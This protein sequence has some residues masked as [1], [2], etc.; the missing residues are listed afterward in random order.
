M[1][2][3]CLTELFVIDSNQMLFDQGTVDRID[4]SATVLDGTGESVS[5]IL[6]WKQSILILIDCNG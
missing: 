1:D 2:C 6:F 4:D 5:V 3:I